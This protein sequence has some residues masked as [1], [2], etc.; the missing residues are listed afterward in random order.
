M[1][2]RRVT[3]LSFYLVFFYVFRFSRKRLLS[4]PVC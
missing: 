2:L 3:T 1:S 4:I